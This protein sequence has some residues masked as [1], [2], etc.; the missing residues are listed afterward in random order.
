MGDVWRLLGKWS[1]RLKAAALPPA[2]TW[3]TEKP[4]KPGWY[5]WRRGTWMFI[6]TVHADDDGQCWA[7]G[8]TVEQLCEHDG[9][10]AG[11]IA[12]PM[13]SPQ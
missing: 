11:P 1:D 8:Y 9:E 2:M 10:W 6:R 13:E 4:T 7:D 5:W 12:P 3:T